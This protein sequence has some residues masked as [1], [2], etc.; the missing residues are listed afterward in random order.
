MNIPGMSKLCAKMLHERKCIGPTAVVDE[1]KDVVPAPVKRTTAAFL[2]TPQGQ[3]C[4][5]CLCA[6]VIGSRAESE[7]YT[8][9]NWYPDHSLDREATNS[10][11]KLLGTDNNSD[12]GRIMQA[13]IV[14][15]LSP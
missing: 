4:Q 13:N 7:E 3:S 9:G 15:T 11:R 12:G 2:H 6:S 8:N 1:H 5:R 14:F 10:A